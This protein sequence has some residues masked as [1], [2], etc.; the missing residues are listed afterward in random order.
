MDIKLSILIIFFIILILFIY[1][2]FT[3]NYNDKY[4]TFEEFHNFMD[5]ILEK[6]NNDKEF[7][8]YIITNYNNTITYKQ[9]NYALEKINYDSI[10]NFHKN[11]LTSEECK[12]II[13]YCQD[14]LQDSCVFV[15]N[16]SI[17]NN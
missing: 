13:K 8:N 6:K 10:I 3:N 17:I 15:D 14:K 11:F 2:L 7:N 12:F 16:K 5:I 4:I 1:Y 9:L